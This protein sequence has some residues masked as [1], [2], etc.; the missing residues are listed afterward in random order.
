LN[1]DL[2]LKLNRQSQKGA[3]KEPKKES[4]AFASTNKEFATHFDF[5]N[6]P[7]EGVGSLKLSK[8]KKQKSITKTL[9]SEEYKDALLEDKIVRKEQHI[10]QAKYNQS[11]FKSHVLENNVNTLNYI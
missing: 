5:S 1:N 8:Q 10:I 6:F 7:K 11:E 2:K 3:K 4:R 9:K